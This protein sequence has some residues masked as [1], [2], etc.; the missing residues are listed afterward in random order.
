MDINLP[1]M[2]GIECVGHPGDRLPKTQI[3]MLTTYE[4]AT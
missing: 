1:G 2:S 4:E 3:L